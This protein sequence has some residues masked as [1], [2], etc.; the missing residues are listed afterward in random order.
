MKQV[1]AT[2]SDAEQ[3]LQQ[4]DK[5]SGEKAAAL[6]AHGMDLLKQAK[7]NVST[8]QAGGGTGQLTVEIA[9]FIRKRPGCAVASAIAIGMLFGLLLTM[10]K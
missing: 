7:E 10:R 1:A 5:S 9:A 6:R 4:A 8:L 2:L 3:L